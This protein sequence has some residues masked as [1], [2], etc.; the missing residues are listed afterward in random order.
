MA[1]EYYCS[2]SIRWFVAMSE[3]DI[4]LGTQATRYTW[5][6]RQGAW[7][8]FRQQLDTVDHALLKT[9]KNIGHDLL[10]YKDTKIAN[11]ADCDGGGQEEQRMALIRKLEYLFAKE[12]EEL[13]VALQRTACSIANLLHDC[14][15][16]ESA[17]A[18]T[19]G[20]LAQCEAV[21]VAR[22]ILSNDWEAQGLLQRLATKA[23]HCLGQGGQSAVLG[24]L[25]RCDVVP[26]ALLRDVNAL[27]QLPTRKCGT[28]CTQL[29]SFRVLN[30]VAG[31]DH[32]V[33]RGIRFPVSEGGETPPPVA[34]LSFCLPFCGEPHANTI[35]SCA[36]GPLPDPITIVQMAALEA[37]QALEERGLQH[38]DEVMPFLEDGD[39]HV[40]LEAMKALCLMA[41]ASPRN[42]YKRHSNIVPTVLAAA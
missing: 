16:V 42:A 9:I 10:G 15:D 39:A 23:L 18:W 25:A 7:E 20:I 8:G 28:S 5:N 40:V 27:L 1:A 29:R 36:S 17:A 11:L 14:G 19:L 41:P 33:I 2:Y 32:D 35:D 24:I 4:A 37:L 26:A 12:D 34:K 30:A 38:V 13:E 6:L 22:A 3:M 31:P 21:P